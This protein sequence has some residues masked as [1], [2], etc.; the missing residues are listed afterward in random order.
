MI[1]LQKGDFEPSLFNIFHIR[2]PIYSEYKI[3]N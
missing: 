1:L 3:L 2:I